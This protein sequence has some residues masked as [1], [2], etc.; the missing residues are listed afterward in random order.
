MSEQ[1]TQYI[2]APLPLGIDTANQAELVP[3][4]RAL[5]VRNCH[6][7]NGALV[8]R[9]AF[10]RL[11]RTAIVDQGVSFPHGEIK[12][13]MPLGDGYAIALEEGRIDAAGFGGTLR[14]VDRSD[15]PVSYRKT[16]HQGP[17]TDEH[18]FDRQ[19]Y[20][21]PNIAVAGDYACIT[22][23]RRQPA[24]GAFPAAN[25]AY[26][27]V[28][29]LATG[30]TLRYDAIGANVGVGSSADGSNPSLVPVAIGSRFFV[31]Y[32]DTVTNLLRYVTLDPTS[33]NAVWAAPVTLV[34]VAAL[35]DAGSFD[36][37]V[38]GTTCYVAYNNAASNLSAVR[39]T[40]SGATLTVTH[41][42]AYAGA[43]L[44][45]CIAV[46]ADASRVLI[47]HSDAAGD[48]FAVVA[49]PATVALDGA[50]TQLSA[51]PIAAT[52]FR[53]IACCVYTAYN[54]AGAS[55]TKA[56]VVW[57]EEASTATARHTYRSTVANLSIAGL[58]AYAPEL[59]RV[60]GVNL[61]HRP[62]RRSGQ[63]AIPAGF[64]TFV[65]LRR[66]Q[67]LEDTYY[68]YVVGVDNSDPTLDSAAIGYGL[69]PVARYGAL[70]AGYFRDTIDGQTICSQG[71]SAV[72]EHG[73][74]YHWVGAE[75]SPT[76]DGSTR[77]SLQIYSLDFGGDACWS[78]VVAN[79]TTLVAGS[80]PRMISPE[81]NS[82]STTSALSRG[83]E[84]IVP[85]HSPP[86]LTL[87]P[88]TG[89]G[90]LT[91][92]AKYYYRQ[93][94]EHV[95][96]RG[97][98][99][100][101]AP[102]PAQEVT[103]AGAENEI[104]LGYSE[105]QAPQPGYDLVR[106]V[107][108]RSIGNP[109]DANAITYYRL[110]EQ[111]IY[112]IQANPT[113][114]DQLADASLTNNEILYTVSG[115]LDNFPPPPSC[116][117]ALWKNRIVALDSE[118]GKIWPSKVILPGEWP[119]FHEGLAVSS[120][121]HTSLPIYLS[122]DT[123]NLIVWW[124][125]AIGVAYGEPG[126]DTGAIG[127]LSQ[128]RLLGQRGIG[129]KY[130]RS[131]V[132]TSIGHMFMSTR[133]VYLLSPDMQLVYI[134]HDVEAYNSAVIV[135]AYVVE[136]PN[137][138]QEVRFE[139]QTLETDGYVS[140]VYDLAKQAWHTHTRGRKPRA[141]A[142]ISGRVY[143]ATEASGTDDPWAGDFL[144]DASGLWIESTDTALP[145]GPASD[146]SGTY[147]ATL[148]TA[149]LTF[150]G[151]VG[152]ARARRLWLLGNFASI[153]AFPALHRPLTAL[154]YRDYDTAVAQ[155]LTV[156]DAGGTPTRIVEASF[157]RQEVTAL[158]L[159]ISGFQRLMGMRIEVEAEK[160]ATRRNNI[161]ATG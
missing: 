27:M 40:A 8:E 84:G 107:V 96:V 145:F 83:I 54:S 26:A 92:T 68:T 72:I 81:V 47:A 9:R 62:F 125:D 82:I 115:E 73:G 146:P 76:Y 14:Q 13:V 130:I 20:H 41:T 5:G 116:A 110:T 30:T 2:D 102:S 3:P 49:L 91:L 108:W 149:W 1:A 114:L 159:S 32:I 98:V 121:V 69:H 42:V 103:L 97:H 111:T 50:R 94:Y 124:R 128:P 71:V 105:F 74:R 132:R 100:R 15:A 139:T 53:Q 109:P 113:H 126:G 57:T 65:G 86:P 39:V 101:G 80:V 141:A 4:T 18:I 119:G 154:A 131:L 48:V 127:S 138:S 24:V 123:D 16:V 29:N 56:T 63:L 78:H 106:I 23:W 148:E 87:T 161:L 58:T 70:V 60:A 155:T 25:T 33:I 28:Y 38:V 34:A 156:N 64:P 37:T 17:L 79:G 136:N 99:Q 66:N 12:R 7:G 43:G 67:T 22:W 137:G 85:M 45:C 75:Q 129:L 55:R 31:F 143:V 134:G 152:T 21:N 36:A 19:S 133:G 89:A 88:G 157:D 6:V 151:K 51:F 52:N 95:D 112:A 46:G 122:E 104:E 142:S 61:C 158:R 140:L 144:P 93:T 160:G 90:T 118:T 117:L 147:R 44:A 35:G 135:G 11:P 77:D 59:L 150:A 120:D 10:T 153:S